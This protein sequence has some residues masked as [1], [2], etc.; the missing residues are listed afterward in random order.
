MIAIP[1]EKL[2]K[3]RDMIDSYYR[4]MDRHM[5][6]HGSTKEDE[7]EALAMIGFIDSLG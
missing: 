4:F 1:R 6:K 7:D 3:I 5:Y 2:E